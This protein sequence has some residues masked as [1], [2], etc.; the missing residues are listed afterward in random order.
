M[1]KLKRLI[2]IIKLSKAKTMMTKLKN[3]R[4]KN[5]VKYDPDTLLQ[6]DKDYFSWKRYKEEL[7][8]WLRNN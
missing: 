8:L 4:R 6:V 2:V 7:E 5:Y 1:K 3:E